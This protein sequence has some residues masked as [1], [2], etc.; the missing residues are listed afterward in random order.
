MKEVRHLFSP[1]SDLKGLGSKKAIASDAPGGLIT[2]PVFFERE[3]IS[4]H[5]NF[6]LT[7]CHSIYRPSNVNEDIVTTQTK[8]GFGVWT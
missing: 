2:E 5:Q 1:K 4:L 6:K 8:A 7:S 3:P